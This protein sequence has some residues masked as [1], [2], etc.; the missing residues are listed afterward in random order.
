[1][2]RILEADLPSTVSARGRLP[3]GVVAGQKNGDQRDDGSAAAKAM[4]LCFDASPIENGHRTRGIGW[5]TYSLLRAF[6]PELLSTH[7]VELHYLK[8]TPLS[9][10][11]PTGGR[12]LRRS[13]VMDWIGTGGRLPS[14]LTVRWQAFAGA[15]RLAADVTAAGGDVFFSTDP[16]T[17][18]HSQRFRTVALLYDLIPLRF[19]AEYLP[20]RALISRA[21]YAWQLR[22]LRGADHLIA[23]SETTRQDAIELLDI[24]PGRISVAYLAVDTAR[25]R[26][27]EHDAA[28]VAV[29]ERFG[30][31]RPYFLYV[32]GIEP[33]KNVD[34]LVRAFSQVMDTCDAV[35]VIAGERGK[36]G[37]QL[38][39]Q[40]EGTPV[41]ERIVWTG[42]VPEEDLPF[43]YAGALALAY[44]S[45]YEGFGLPVLEA[46]SCGAP[47]LTS[48]L[49]SLPEVAG[50]AALYVDPGSPAEL[51]A[52]LRRLA[53]EP[54]LRAELRERGLER[55]QRFS[56]TD[57][58]ERV[59][60][61]CRAVAEGN[62]RGR[63]TS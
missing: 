56:W 35:L 61:V 29:A 27:V 3:D 9:E 13:W 22:Q 11:L 44:P 5:C 59:L 20:R 31:D 25:F 26:P 24:P 2:R 8:R 33:R 38:R 43:L 45:L 21:N 28:R 14:K 62:N 47:V 55:A 15:A 17:V 49:S 23:I 30:V 16:H 41:G 37:E 46:M 4:T 42:F 19:P 36:A 54:A 34:G 51:A 6:T 60:Q 53:A 12:F 39:R 1:M 10:E 7:G 32:G 50:D 48:P 40:L 52:A 57:T 63:L 18:P 58:A